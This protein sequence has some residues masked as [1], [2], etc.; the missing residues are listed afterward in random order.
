MNLL[1]ML[2]QANIFSP[3]GQMADQQFP[4]GSIG[5]PTDTGPQVQSMQ[6]DKGFDLNAAIQSMLNP[7]DE[8]FQ[9]YADLIKSMPQRGDYP[10]PG[11]WTKVRA[12]IAKMGADNPMQAMQTRET[13]EH[14]AYYKALEDWNRQ[15]E[16]TEKI[17]QMESTRNV[18]LRTAGSQA[19]QRQQQQEK[20]DEQERRN[21]KLEEQS[22][23]KIEIS[24]QRADAY[25]KS[26]QWAMDHPNHVIKEDDQGRLIGIDPTT[27]EAQFITNEDGSPVKSIN[28]TP[29]AKA[30]LKVKTEKELIQERGAVSAKNTATRQ[31]TSLTNATTLEQT[32]Q[33]NRIAL[34]AVKKQLSKEL[35]PSASRT[36]RINKAIEIINARPE[37]AKYLVHSGADGI[38]GAPT[39]E[40]RIPDDADPTEA[41]F[42]RSQMGAGNI[43]LPSASN[44]TVPNTR[45]ELTRPQGTESAAMKTAR[46]KVEA[47]YVLITDGRS[48]GQV[49]PADVSKL[50]AGWSVVK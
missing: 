7:R 13:I 49:K 8:Q 11:F 19:I 36:E 32:R 40:I 15:L 37:L 39:G 1:D 10:E 23:Q 17:S 33:Q 18:N 12:N 34:D 4:M 6:Q 42:I 28:L 16:P 48:F 43:S 31:A 14:P 5:G 50:P 46:S 29:E 30:N 26:K 20:L 45:P 44:A 35:S 38:S 25:T 22:Q 47:G 27:D 3:T 2:K 41:E 24:K 9:N 21:L